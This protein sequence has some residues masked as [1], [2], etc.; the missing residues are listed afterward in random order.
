MQDGAE[1]AEIGIAASATPSPNRPRGRQQAV[2]VDVSPQGLE[3]ERIERWPVT[4]VIQAGNSKGKL[5]AP[6]LRV[7]VMDGAGIK[8]GSVRIPLTRAR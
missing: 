4:N 2:R 1:F 7:V 3:A 5:F 8:S 6:K